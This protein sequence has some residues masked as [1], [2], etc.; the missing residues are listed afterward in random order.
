MA[1]ALASVMRHGSAAGYTYD[2]GHSW[3]PDADQTRI[4]TVTQQEAEDAA[5]ATAP[6]SPISA[7]PERIFTSPGVTV[8]R[9]IGTGIFV[10]LLG[11]FTLFVAIEQGATVVV[12]TIIG[13]VFIGG[14]IGYLR[15]VAPPPFRVALAAEALRYEEQGMERVVIPWPNVVKIKEERFPNGLPI[16]LAVYKRVG[17][18]GL[19]RAFLVWRDDLPAFDELVTALRDH[20]PATTRWNVETVH[21]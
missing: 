10:G 1:D 15:V 16:S 5:A 9:K 11:L 8:N 2:S 14:F 7:P 19:H 6:P 3:L 18:K 4:G 13:V 20:V 21:E 12:S 17:A